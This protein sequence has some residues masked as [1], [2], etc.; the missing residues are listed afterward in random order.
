MMPVNSGQIQTVTPTMKWRTLLA[1]IRTLDG[2][3]LRTSAVVLAI[4]VSA[5][6]WPADDA[7]GRAGK[8]WPAV[9]GDHG[10]TRYSGLDQINLGSIKRL[11]GAWLKELDT[12]TRSPPVLAND[13]LYI[14][15]ATTTYALDPRTGNTIWKYTPAHGAP[16]RGGVA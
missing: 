15:D 11:G 13:M 8:D 16:A 6:A 14:N 9:G 7:A 4:C 12:A 1:N 5:S 3:F 10:N 2:A